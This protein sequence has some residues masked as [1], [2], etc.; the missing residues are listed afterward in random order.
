MIDKKRLMPTL[1]GAYG[2][3]NQELSEFSIR[4]WVDAL[5]NI[6]AEVI[7]E[8]FARHLRDPDAGRWCP[9]PADILRQIKGDANDRALIAWGEVLAAA[10]AGGRRFEGPMQQA[11]EGMG[12]MARIRLSQ[13][14][15]LPFLQRQF[16]AAFKAYHAR[17][18]NPPLIGGEVQR[19]EA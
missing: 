6:D 16:V 19:L 14:T 18:E 13:E 10:K 9:K 5:D 3:Y 15:E 17:A 1:A 2:F 12:G 11:I 7:D 4:I 8:A